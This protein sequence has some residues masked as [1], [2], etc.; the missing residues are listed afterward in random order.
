MGSPTCGL[1]AGVPAG[2]LKG[3]LMPGMPGGMLGS[4]G[5]GGGCGMSGVGSSGIGCSFWISN[6]GRNVTVPGITR[7][8]LRYTFATL[9]LAEGTGY[10]R[11]EQVI[12]SRIV[13]KRYGSQ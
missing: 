7:L 13:P 9:W 4:T 12:G 5:A 11:L 8:S 10:D 1:S 2:M 6:A 3:S